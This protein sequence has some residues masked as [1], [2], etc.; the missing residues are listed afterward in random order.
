[1]RKATY[2]KLKRTLTTILSLTIISGTLYVYFHTG[3]FTIHSYKIVGVPEQ[4]V[5]SI[6]HGARLV[7]EQKLF[8]IL[9][10]NRTVSFHDDELKTLVL[11]TLP[12]SKSISIYPSGLHTLSIKVVP[13]VPLFAVSDT[14]AIAEDGT[15]YKEIIPLLDFPRLEVASSSSVHP[16]VMR[17]VAELVEKID[18]VL[19]EVHYVSV[20]EF[21][22]I[23]LYDKNKR[24]AIIISSNANMDMVWSNLLSAIDTEPLKGK[25]KSTNEHLQYIDTRFGNKVFYKFTNAKD[26]VIIPP[27]DDTASTTT[28][29]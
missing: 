19:Y 22:D 26:T 23:R 28:A 1:M 14:H 10:G 8:Y 2:I 21:N 12:N 15:V 29:L 11:E 17:S 16:K 18:A 9:P 25:L 6:E 4:Y 13:H 5:E 3:L 27:H 24:G 7:A 20:D